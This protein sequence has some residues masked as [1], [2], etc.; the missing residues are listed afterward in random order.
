M[1]TDEYGLSVST[2]STAARDA[3]VEGCQAKLTMYP[4][5]IELFD[6]AIAADP[7]F[8][9]AHAVKAHALLER[10]DAAAARASIGAAVALTGQL[11]SREKSHVGFFDLLLAGEAEAALSVLHA[12]LDAWPRDVL[13]LSTAA[14]TN[15]LIGS[16][17]RS[18]Q[19]RMLLALL[20]RLAPSYANDWWFGA[21]HG[22]A[23]SENGQRDA[24]RRRIEQSLAQN[25]KNPWAAHA[26]G[27]LCY[28]EG[29]AEAACAFLA[30]WLPGYPR[31][32]ALYSHLNWHFAIARLEAGDPAAA[33]RLYDEAFAP[34]VHSGPPRG[35]ITDPV[36]F[37]W[38]WE[39]AGHPRDGGAWRR[40]HYFA[41]AAFPRSAVA[42]CDMHVALARA[43]GGDADAIESA[44]QQ[45]AAL[46]ER[47]RYPSGPLVPAVS[48]A[49]AAFERQ[50]FAAAIDLLEPIAGELERIGGSRAQLDLVEFTLLR[51]YLAAARPDDAVRMLRARGRGGSSPPVAGLSAAPAATPVARSALQPV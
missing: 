35:K 51:A 3:Y 20:D 33:R 5:A 13:V 9:L 22:M 41:T 2:S 32:G 23:Y 15:G 11:S 19:K 6:R 7:Q 17:G 47:G 38:R 36:S 27:H 25:S 48:R 46:A 42:F 14:F 44:V 39:L 43:V 29:D 40:V 16:S 37:L 18:G 24:A 26:F 8:A 21:H 31:G 1:L 28:E 50:D 10:G 12:H 4:G 30:S 34:D 45:I 49:F